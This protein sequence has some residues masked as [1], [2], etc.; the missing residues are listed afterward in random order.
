MEQSVYK[1]PATDDGGR[2]IN[3]SPPSGK[4]VHIQEEEDVTIRGG[5]N[6]DLPQLEGIKKMQPENL[7]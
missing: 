6:A 1:E 5:G 2:R 3:A 7:N 4:T